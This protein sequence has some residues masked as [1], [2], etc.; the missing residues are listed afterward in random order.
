MLKKH[1]VS[2]EVGKYINLYHTEEALFNSL[3]NC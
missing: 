1:G 3:P 2:G